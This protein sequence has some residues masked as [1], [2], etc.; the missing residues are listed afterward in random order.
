MFSASWHS[1]YL[2]RTDLVHVA[3]EEIEEKSPLDL[4]SEAQA[5]IR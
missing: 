2:D 5:S 1:E 4:S 3:P